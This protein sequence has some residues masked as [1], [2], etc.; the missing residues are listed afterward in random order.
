MSD[1]GP[2]NFRTH[3]ELQAFLALAEKPQH[4]NVK[5]GSPISAKSATVTANITR[6]SF[7]PAKN[8][9]RVIYEYGV[10][11]VDSDLN[12]G[13]E[14]NSNRWSQLLGSFYATGAMGLAGSTTGFLCT[15]AGLSLNFN[16]G[17]GLFLYANSGIPLG[18]VYLQTARSYATQ[19]TY[20]V[21]GVAD[22]APA[23]LT[24]P[25]SARTDT[26]WLEL[27]SQDYGPLDDNNL[28]LNNP[29][30][31]TQT[32]VSHRIKWIGIVR[33]WEGSGALSA[34]LNVSS[35][36]FYNA[37]R[38]YTPLAQLARYS[39]QAVINIAD[40]TDVRTIVPT[41]LKGYGTIAATTANVFVP[42]PLITATSNIEISLDASYNS[43]APTYPIYV[44]SRSVVNT[45]G[46]F[47]V[48]LL[49]GNAPTGGTT[50]SW[51][52]QI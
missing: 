39:G 31:S 26:I 10:P 16:I 33:V 49:G 50:F 36:P 44:A 7:T 27:F 51:R 42:L 30:I 32:D 19:A 9:D 47:I 3:E 37:A 41:G 1:Q 38:Y 2:G 8:Y 52:V 20:T 43:V 12:E 22:T 11:L 45:A 5:L 18:V 14:I 17:G 29:N 48:H 34:S 40:I 28:Y 21:G 15:G 23:T 4:R 6:D 13:L 24:T 25:G 35:A 46:G